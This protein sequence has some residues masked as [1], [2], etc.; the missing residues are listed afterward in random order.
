VRARRRLFLLLFFI[1][2]TAV[3]VALALGVEPWL[4]GLVAVVVLSPSLPILAWMT[5]RLRAEAIPSSE[6]ER[7]G[8]TELA[9]GA[10]RRS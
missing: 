3:A 1:D 10:T 8:H 9:A 7:L 4:V 2:L 5:A 6:A